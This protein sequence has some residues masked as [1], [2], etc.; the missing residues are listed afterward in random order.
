[1]LPTKPERLSSTRVLGNNLA[2]T[3]Y[4]ATRFHTHRDSF[5]TYCGR[6]FCFRA[7]T[8]SPRRRNWPARYT[9]GETGRPL[10]TEYEGRRPGQVPRPRSGTE[11]LQKTQRLRAWA[12]TFG[13]E[14]TKRLR[15]WAATFVQDSRGANFV[16]AAQN[17]INT[18][19]LGEIC[20]GILARRMG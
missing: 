19:V 7:K 15:A 11:I 20:A 12:A 8:P 2:G 14:A 17:M 6:A 18:G 4:R 3:A 9:G 1:M 16:K 13:D 10:G 5:R